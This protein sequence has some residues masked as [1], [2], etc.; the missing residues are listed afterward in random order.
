MARSKVSWSRSLDLLSIVRGGVYFPEF[1]FS[2]SIKSV[3]PAVCPGFGYDDLEGIADGSAASAAF[4][5]PASGGVPEREEID[6]LRAA[7]VLIVI[8]IRW[9]SWRCT[10]HSHG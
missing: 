10:G 2:N 3:A 9:R 7:L 6:Q 1:W 5:R 4:L 8:A